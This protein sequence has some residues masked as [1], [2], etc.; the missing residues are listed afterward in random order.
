VYDA[1]SALVGLMDA[2]HTVGEVYN[3][4]GTE[5]VEILD[6][7]RRVMDRTES[8]SEIV[9]VPYG[10]A[11]EENFEDMPRRVPDTSKIQRAIGWRLSYSLDDVLD[12]VIAYHREIMQLPTVVREVARTA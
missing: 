4:G 7:A 8:S 9:F 3:I 1:V 6:L 2:D 11:Y 5:E 12:S 10:V